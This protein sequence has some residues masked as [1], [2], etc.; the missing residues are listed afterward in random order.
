MPRC[1]PRPK[2]DLLNYITSHTGHGSDCLFLSK[3]H[4]KDGSGVLTPWQ[5]CIIEKS[6]GTIATVF[7]TVVHK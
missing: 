3:L 6:L 1:D 7:L 5:I 2:N 4:L